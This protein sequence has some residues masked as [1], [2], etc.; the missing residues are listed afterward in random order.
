ME[1]MMECLVAATENRDA[2]IDVN[3]GN[4]D[5]SLKEIKVGQEHLKEE[6]LAKMEAK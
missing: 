2:K 6:M 5:A 4:T 3:Q 1:Q